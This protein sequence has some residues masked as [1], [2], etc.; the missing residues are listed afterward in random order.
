MK[1]RFYDDDGEP[2]AVSK[3]STLP[4]LCATCTAHHSGYPGEQKVLCNLNRADCADDEIFICFAYEPSSP[5]VSKEA[6]L[7]PRCEKI[8]IPYDEEPSE[9]GEPEIVRF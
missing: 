9:P 3:L 5:G 6:V 4:D 1:P 2:R 8:G 7:R